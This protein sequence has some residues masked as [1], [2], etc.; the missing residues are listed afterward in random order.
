MRPKLHDLYDVRR[1]VV[2]WSDLADE[3]CGECGWPEACHPA[4]VEGA[5][6]EE[7]ALGIPAGT[8]AAIRRLWRVDFMGE[9]VPLPAW[10]R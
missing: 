7:R 5:V 10:L 8:F 3:F 9:D 1:P 2:N 4:P 6:R